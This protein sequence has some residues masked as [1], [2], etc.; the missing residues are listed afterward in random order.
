MTVPQADLGS[1]LGAMESLNL[2]VKEY[3]RLEL[4]AMLFEQLGRAKHDLESSLET[5]FDLLHHKYNFDMHLPLVVDGFP[6]NDVDVVSIRLVRAKIIRLRND[7]AYVLELLEQQLEQRLLAG[8]ASQP[9]Q[10]AP[11]RSS[12]SVPFALVRDVVAG[13]P[14][15]A[16]GLRVGDRVCV[17]DGDVK[18]S[19]HE[20]L[21]KVAERV[22][23]KQGQKIAVE[24]LR[25]NET[26]EL[27]LVP[28]DDWAGRG[29][30]GCLLV[31]I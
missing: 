21:A 26:V 23:S 5:L 14:A 8:L 16:A 29:L 30:L 24:V 22:R 13:G 20:K 17:F 6:R 1:F 4:Q 27:E 11:V 2:D 7:L 19:N 9:T 18:A 3:T 28:T 31:P 25:G 10:E 12:A 15:S